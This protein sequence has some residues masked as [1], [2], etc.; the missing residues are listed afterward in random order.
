VPSKSDVAY[1]VHPAIMPEEIV[2][3][4]IRMFSFA[5]DLVLDPFTGS[6]TTLK[7]AQE[8]GRSSVGYEI[9]EEFRE[10][11]EKKLSA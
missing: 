2:R 3:R 11:I 8:L 5:G 7:V 9:N 4:C 1:G 6:G 10:I